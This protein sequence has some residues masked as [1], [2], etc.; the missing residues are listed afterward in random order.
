M[1]QTRRSAAL[2]LHTTLPQR[3][4]CWEMLDKHYACLLNTMTLQSGE[5]IIALLTS[6][7]VHTVA[8]LTS[9][10]DSLVMTAGCIVTMPNFFQY[11]LPF[12]S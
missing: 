2:K 4:A 11:P 3:D 5:C 10:S 1:H 9:V 8:R 7:P 6:Q 12:S